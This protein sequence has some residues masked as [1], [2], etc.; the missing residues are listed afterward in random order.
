MQIVK[1]CGLAWEHMFVPKPD[2]KKAVQTKTW[3]VP[4][5]TDLT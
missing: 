2:G 5:A 1:E 3:G 4:R